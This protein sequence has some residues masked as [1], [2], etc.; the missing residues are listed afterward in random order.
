MDM[1]IANKHALCCF[2]TIATVAFGQKLNDLTVYPAPPPP[3]LPPAGGTFQDP[4]F[5][6]T[7]LRVTD[8]NDGPLSAPMYSATWPAFNA[9]SSRILYFNVTG[10]IMTADLDVPNRKVSN[11]RFL[12]AT[13]KGYGGPAYWDRTDPNVLYIFCHAILYEYSFQTGQ[14]TQIVDFSTLIPGVANV[15]SRGMSFDGNRFQLT[16]TDINL[17]SIPG[18]DGV[19]IYDRSVNSFVYYLAPDRINGE[20]KSQMDSSGRY[21]IAGYYLADSVT[22]VVVEEVEQGHYEVNF[23]VLATYLNLS[24]YGWFMGYRKLDPNGASYGTAYYVGPQ[25][26]WADDQHFAL[27]DSNGEWLTGSFEVDDVAEYYNAAE[28]WTVPSPWQWVWDSQPPNAHGHWNWIGQGARPSFTPFPLDVVYEGEI[29]QT[30][31]KV[32]PLTVVTQY[33]TAHQTANPVGPVTLPNGRVYATWADFQANESPAAILSANPVNRRIAKHYSNP[34]IAANGTLGYWAQPHAIGSTDN[35]VVM[36]A[37]NYGNPNQVDLFIAFI[38]QIATTPPTAPPAPTCTYTLS[39]TTLNTGAAA[40]AG[41]VTVTPSAGT[42]AAPSVSSNVS[43]ASISI[44]GNTVNWSVTANSTSQ[45]RTGVLS[46]AGQSVVIT[47][48]F[49]VTTISMTAFPSS[50]NWAITGTSSSNPQSVSLTFAGGPGP[51]WTASSNQ[52]N[53]RVSPTSGVGNATL[54]IT[55]TAGLSG[56]VAINAAGVVNSPQ[57]VQVQITIPTVSGPFGSFDTPLNDARNVSAAVAV[58]GWALDSVGID[59][60]DIWREPMPSEPPGL[61]YIGDAVFVSGA[62]PDVAAA[63]SQYPNAN[64]A[65]W[66]YLLLS[67]FL[68]NANNTLGSANGTY[69]LHALAHNKSGATVDLG[70]HTIM[71][72]NSAATQPFGTIDTPAQGQTISGNAYVNFGWALTPMPAAIPTDG[73]TITV[74]IDGITV[75][76]PTYNQFR[77]D[78]AT[79]FPGYANSNGAIGF[80]TIDTTK[81]TNGLHTISWNAWDNE[82]R[83]NGIGSRFFNVLNGADE[84]SP[85]AQSSASQSSVDSA[86]GQHSS[87]AFDQ[88]PV[89]SNTVSIEVQ[90]M[91]LVQVPV[92]GTTGYIV[93]N[94]QKQPLPIGSTLQG[95]VFYWQLAPVF[96]GEYDMVFEG[97]GSLPTHLRV[98]VN[99]KTYSSGSYQ[100]VQ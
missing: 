44:S 91:D 83:G 27:Q 13:P 26:P 58:T 3:T 59:K 29:F 37:S 84:A 71:V 68:P 2:F 18:A 10:N 94:G 65:G 1:R 76:H 9:D 96:L 51:S 22:N 15:S 60:V 20:V 53:I 39:T 100:A 66:G 93:A 11:K 34:L 73:S 16:F 56:I 98:V 75:A 78:I 52:P 82:V 28:Q 85:A 70:A 95:G 23:G 69:T 61:V 5:G 55:A 32:P 6:T 21:I 77:G 74:N 89:S 7:I 90:E 67:N 35:R 97:P 42:C 36:Y 40:A 4:A 99:P 64:E 43:W 86:K 79:L 87:H 46:I 72:N 54:Q 92:S 50:L 41:T 38:D 48:A 63:F 31:L 47:Q 62:R 25:T 12:P 81:L 45:A 14:Y 49:V 30:S 80:A 17:N 19:F 88:S 8:E 33:D 57:V 24:P